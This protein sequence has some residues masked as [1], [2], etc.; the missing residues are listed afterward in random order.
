MLV[1]SRKCEESIR[2]SDDIVITVLEIRGARVKLGIQAP[3]QMRVLRTELL[4]A[5]EVPPE[6]VPT[7]LELTTPGVT[8]S[9]R[10]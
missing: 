10:T 1:L 2:I 5:I 6:S 3:V 4:A 9:P 8:A 7:P